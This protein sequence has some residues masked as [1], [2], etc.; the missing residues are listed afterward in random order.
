MNHRIVSAALAA[1]LTSTAA[2]AQSP[3]DNARTDLDKAVS[4]LTATQR[5]YADL[6]RGLYRDINKL[7][8]EALALGKEFKDL[9]REEERRTASLK[10]LEREIEARKTDFNYSAGILN[11]YSKAFVTRLHPAENQLHKEAVDALDQR[12]ASLTDDPKAELI[13]RAKVLELG[14]NRIGEVAGG[15]TFEGKALRNGSESIEGMLLVAGPSV[16]FS[17]KDKGFEGVA[18]FAETGTSLPTV[19]AI[20]GSK[21]MIAGTIREGHGTLP[22]DGTMGKAIEVAAAQESLW[23]TIEKGGVVGHAILVLGAI[24]FLIAIF[25][26]WEVSRIRVPSRSTI[27]LILDDLLSGNREAAARK[28]DAIDGPAGDLVR[29]GVAMFYEKR[30]VLEEALFEKLVAVKPRLDRFLP[31][32][33]LTA[34]A[35]PLMG[36]LGTVLGIIKTFKA[37]ALYGTGNAKAFSAGISE[38]LI[39]TAEGLIVAIPV[40]VIHGM[41]KSYVKGRFSE[42][43][44]I[45]IALVNGTTERERKAGSADESAS[46]DD[47]VE[48]TPT[49]A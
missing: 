26:V 40:L 34:A 7:D 31:F 23:K 18:T 44:G 13:E 9:Q 45:G 43:E 46:P 28:A 39:T 4:E 27:N 2:R 14:L 37:M 21:G 6:R 22:L 5:E 12:A 36:L 10:T 1:I 15:Q 49:P 47:D 48:L 16:F 33:A 42:F 38:A 17:S 35:A 20:E 41:L 8:D 24:S 19:V 32:L 30:R 29:T 25:K 3:A 11:Q